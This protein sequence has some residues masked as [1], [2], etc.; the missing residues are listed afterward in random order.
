MPPMRPARSSS[1]WL[2]SVGLG[3]PDRL[4]LGAATGHSAAAI[5]RSAKE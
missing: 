1:T 4:A 5:R 3:R 2:A